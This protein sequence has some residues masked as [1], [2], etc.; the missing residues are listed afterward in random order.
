MRIEQPALKGYLTLLTPRFAGSTPPKYRTIAEGNG[1]A[2][3]HAAGQDVL[4][5][6]DE[7]IKESEEGVKLNARA[8]FARIGKEREGKPAL[9]RL[10][11]VEGSIKAEGVTLTCPGSA[12]LVVREKSIDVVTDGDRAAVKLDLSGR[13]KKLPV[14]ITTT[15]KAG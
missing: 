1:V 11:V 3:E 5:L 2:I 8:G 6:A 13:L 14:N 10:M 12:S 9:L 7:V 15:R 4:F